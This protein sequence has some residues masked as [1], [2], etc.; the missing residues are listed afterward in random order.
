MNTIAE[1]REQDI[2]PDAA[3]IDSANFERRETVRAVV[4]DTL[5]RVALLNVTN[6]G[7]H[8]LPGGGIETGES[9][10][11]ALD[12]EVL[13]EIG[14][15]IEILSELGKI[16]EYRDEW[17]QIQTSF[18]YL[19][20]QVGQRQQNSL[21]EEEQTHG[22]ETIWV[23]DVDDAIALL[24]ADEPTGYDGKRMKP[25]DVAIL[26]AAREQLASEGAV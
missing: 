4:V 8:K 22:F 18:C 3:I 12:R 17:R 24:E 7:F 19:A 16:V 6:R 15:H 10:A 26:K 9:R 25:R 1:I 2:N 5:G 23:S 11:Q 14:C 20:K 13:E 21:T